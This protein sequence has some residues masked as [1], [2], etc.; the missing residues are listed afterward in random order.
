MDELTKEIDSQIFP[1]KSALPL[2]DQTQ[3][4]FNLPLNFILL[5]SKI[6]KMNVL[7]LRVPIIEEI[8]KEVMKIKVDIKTS[9]IKFP[10]TIKNLIKF[11]QFKHHV[12]EEGLQGVIEAYKIVA[13]NEEKEDIETDEATEK[14]ATD[15][16]KDLPPEDTEVVSPVIE[17]IPEETHINV[18]LFSAKDIIS[19]KAEHQHSKSEVIEKF[20]QKKI[21]LKQVRHKTLAKCDNLFK[22]IE[23]LYQNFPHFAEIIEYLED[24]CH[25]QKSGDGVFYIP[26]T[27]LIGGAGVGKTFFTHDLAKLVSTHF[28]LISMESMT[29][30]W[31]MVGSSSSW[32][33]ASPGKVFNTLIDKEYLNPIFVL[34][35]IDKCMSGNYPPENTLLP[36]LEQFTAQSFKDECIPLKIDASNIIWFATAN[37]EKSISVPLKNRFNMFNVPEPNKEQQKAL[38]SNIYKKILSNNSW[39]HNFDNNLSGNSIDYLANQ[40]TSGDRDLRKIITTACAKAIRANRKDIR[41]EDFNIVKNPRVM[42]F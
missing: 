33:S 39:G 3:V 4:F 34:D 18:E 13:K 8:N 42:G 25:L 11:N 40:M 30:A 16:F 15:S 35:E 20:I 17:D 26:P 29:A 24:Y 10:A 41:P 32:T 37:E 22:G 27:L 6:E 7:D 23:T 38:I 14:I 21:G 12:T 5:F 9:N 28:E 31:V 2:E 36:L 19:F 1:E